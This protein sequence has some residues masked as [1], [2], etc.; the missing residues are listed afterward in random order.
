MEDYF[1][2]AFRT[3]FL[4]KIPD[5]EEKYV[6]P[7]TKL[8]EKRRET[9]DVEN[10]LNA[11]KEEFSMD[12][13]GLQQR[14][15]EIFLKE[16]KLKDS[17]SQFDRFIRE[18]DAKYRRA[19]NKMEEEEQTIILKDAE[20]A[21]LKIENKELSIEKATF[22]ERLAKYAKFQEFLD[23]VL[24]VAG[25][26]SDFEEAGQVM[27]RNASLVNIY[28]ELNEQ[29]I[30]LDREFEKERSILH[31]VSVESK[32][33]AMKLNNELCEL[34][35]RHD[36]AVHEGRKWENKLNTLQRESGVEGLK[37]AKSMMAAHNLVITRLKQK[38]ETRKKLEAER[39]DIYKRKDEK[40]VPDSVS[41]D[42]T[43]FTVERAV[44]ELVEI[45]QTIFDLELICNE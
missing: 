31:E 30:K 6:S 2:A 29:K 9:Q 21:R 13:Q 32:N 18:N 35:T 16:Q 1:D 37:M 28:N 45:G 15:N 26:G 4:V 23:R 14:K 3:K 22:E 34:Q 7:A 39:S 12:M 41:R 43:D 17:L 20:L 5:R 33:E 19:V 40:K 8:L 44:V 10:S 27:S 24:K 38:E 36:K 42:T 25:L 11:L